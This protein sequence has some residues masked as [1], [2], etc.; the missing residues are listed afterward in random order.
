MNVARWVSS[1]DTSRRHTRAS[2]PRAMTMSLSA[3]WRSSSPMRP[4]RRIR[5]SM[6][7][8]SSIVYAPLDDVAEHGLEVARLGLRQEA[9]LAQVEAE[10]RDV[11]LGDRPGGAQERAVATEDDEGV[12]RRQLRAAAAPGRRPAPATRRRRAPGTSRTPGRSARPRPRWSGCRRSRCGRWSR[13]LLGCVAATTAAMRSPI[14]AQPGP[15]GQVD[16][17]LAVAL[18]PQERRGDDVAGPE[19]DVAGGLHDVRSRTSR[20]MAGSRTTPRSVRPLPAS[21]W[22]L[23]RATIGARGP[24]RR[25]DRP[26]DLVERDERDVDDGEVDRLGQGLGGQRAGVGPL[27]AD[28]AG[29]ATKRLGELSTTHVESVDAPAPR[30]NRTSVKPPVEAP[31][32]SAVRPRGSIANASRAAASL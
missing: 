26:E 1:M 17:E 16:E 6:I 30:C 2:A 15:G 21:N 10:Q 23:T 11:D 32:S 5:P 9:D 18:R 13:V 19:A 29:V 28:D 27:Q 12:G 7:I 4:P 24:E 22:G 31:T 20:W 8:R 3:M 14:S 25:D